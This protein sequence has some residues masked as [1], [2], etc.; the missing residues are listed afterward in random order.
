MK[1]RRIISR[2]FFVF[3]LFCSTV[4]QQQYLG[5]PINPG[6]GCN[7]SSFVA[8]NASRK[9]LVDICEAGREQSKYEISKLRGGRGEAAC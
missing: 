1:K 5:K 3:L 4:L 9:N 7:K 2:I 6:V 8:P